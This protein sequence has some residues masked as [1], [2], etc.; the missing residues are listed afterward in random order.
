[1]IQR[2]KHAN[3]TLAH[4]VGG[5][6]MRPPSSS[7]AAAHLI[8][9]FKQ[10]SRLAVCATGEQRYVLIL[11][12]SGRRAGKCSNSLWPLLGPG[13]ENVPI[14]ASG[15]HFGHFQGLGPES[16]QIEASGAHFGHFWDQGWKMLKLRLLGLILAISGARAG[17][18]S[19]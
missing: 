11:A 7:Q 5:R 6:K 17:K 18:C 8:H 19:N 9:N 16:A 1:M 3:G 14:E 15:V 2:V 4:K 12:V 10:Y 13:L